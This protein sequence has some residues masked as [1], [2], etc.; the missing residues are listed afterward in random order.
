[1]PAIL[2]L[3]FVQGV[4]SAAVQAAGPA[5]IA[6]AVPPERRGRAYGI[7]IGSIYAGLTLGPICA[8]FLVDL[9]GWRAV[10]LAGG[11]LV[12][13]LLVPIHFMLT[14]TWRQPP[15]GAVHLPSTLLAVVA[16]LA[17]VGG[18]ATLREGAIGYAAMVLG[19]ALLAAFVFWQRRL[20]QP[21]LNVELLMKNIV[22][23]GALL[24]QWLLYCNAFGTVFLLSLYMQT[25]LGHSANT[26]GEVLAIGTLLMAL[27]APFAG[28]LADR[29][30]PAFIASCGV[31][32]ALLAALLATRLGADSPLLPVGLVLAVQG[33]GFAFFSSPNMKMVMNAVP[34][35]RSSIASAL[36]ATARS[37]G[38]VSGMLI[39]GALISLSLGH[40]PVG[41]DP[42]RYVATMH[43]SF[44]ILAAI[45]ALALAI[46]LLSRRE[47]P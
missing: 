20:A 10:F 13:A 16:M 34:P 14:A 4:A 18:A 15:R 37:L 9:W 40:D 27:I 46:S 17:L 35:N 23:R 26:A 22:L 45:T 25:V 6:D 38:M 11:A 3:R 47:E 32:V 36:S 24:V 43:T 7:T 31:G 29:R 30:A 44:W 2:T 12:L 33:L 28:I 5:I 8:G 21:L 39:V 19:L 41:A 42:A 1:M